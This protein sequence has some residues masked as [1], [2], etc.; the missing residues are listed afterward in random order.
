MRI[1]DL[2]GRRGSE[3]ASRRNCRA[4]RQHHDG[5]L[6]PR[7]RDTGGFRDG[8]LRSGDMGYVDDD[9]FLFIVDRLKDMI[10]SGGENVYS[11]KSRMR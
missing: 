8:W 6:E 2:N 5:V 9:G 4:G 10:V 7:A 3:R 11:A 1:T